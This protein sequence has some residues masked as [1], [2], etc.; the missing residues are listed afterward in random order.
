MHTSNSPVLS[1]HKAELWP[2]VSVALWVCSSH[3]QSQ[4]L[5]PLSIGQPLTTSCFIAHCQRSHGVPMQQKKKCHNRA[6]CIPAV[7]HLE[8]SL[9]S[10]NYSKE[11]H[12]TSPNNRREQRLYLAAGCF[13]RHSVQIVGQHVKYHTATRK[14]TEVTLSTVNTVTAAPSQSDLLH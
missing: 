3:I 9:F 2:K 11:S 14:R 1:N 5:S 4:Q 8:C 13:I 12:H 10:Y 6:A 7:F